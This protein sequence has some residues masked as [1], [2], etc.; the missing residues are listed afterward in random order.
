MIKWGDQ[1]M[2]HL[3]TLLLDGN[4][5]LN[6]KSFKGPFES[7]PFPCLLCLSLKGTSI[8]QV[9]LKQIEEHCINLT[10]LDLSQIKGIPAKDRKEIAKRI[11]GQK[12]IQL[13]PRD[14]PS[15]PTRQPLRI[16]AL[17]YEK[18]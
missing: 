1:P 12:M 9:T 2:C 18:M 6:D 14:I 7:F 17:A 15:A 4:S 8:T 13:K 16:Q 11:T 5:E 3:K 10:K